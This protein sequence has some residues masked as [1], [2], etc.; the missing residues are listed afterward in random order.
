MLVAMAVA[1]LTI[2]A[3]GAWAQPGSGSVVVGQTADGRP[4]ILAVIPLKYADPM[5]L[6]QLFGG[7]WIQGGAGN[8]GAG[9]NGNDHGSGYQR[10]GLDRRLNGGSSRDSGYQSGYGGYQSALGQYNNYPGYVSP[11]ASR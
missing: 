6:A 2:L 8:L 10:R 3:Y 5:A 4:L 7:T 11:Y 9:A 1:A